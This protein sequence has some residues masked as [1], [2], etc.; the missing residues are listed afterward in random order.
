MQRNPLIK[1]PIVFFCV[2]LLVLLAHSSFAGI[3]LGDTITSTGEY[4]VVDANQLRGGSHTVSDMTLMYTIP[5]ARLK[6]GMSVW[7]VD[8]DSATDGKQGK[9]FRLN[10]P[11]GEIITPDP[12]DP[13]VITSDIDWDEV[14]A[15]LVDLSDHSVIELD[16]VTDAGSGEIITAAERSQLSKAYSWGDHAGKYLTS[17]TE[18]DPV[19]A[20]SDAAGIS[21]S[22]IVNWSN[23]YIWGN[24]NAAGYLK[25]LADHSV[26]ELNDVASAGSGSIITVEE[27]EKLEGIA[28]G[29]EDT[30]DD[31]WTGT[32][33]VYTNTGNVGIGTNSVPAKLTIFQEADTV[34]NA[35]LDKYG[36]VIANPAN[37]DNEEIGL[38]FRI[39]SAISAAKKPGAAITH[40]RTGGG[41]KGKMHFKTYDGTNLATKMTIDEAGNMGVG[42]ITPEYKL[43]VEGAVNAEEMFVGGKA[44]IGTTDPIANLTVY[45]EIDTPDDATADKFGLLIA[46][47]ENDTNEEVG[48][49]F[50]ISTT[51]GERVPGAAITHERTGTSSIGKL[52]FKTANSGYDL[53]TRMTIDEEGRVGIGTEEF[54]NIAGQSNGRLIIKATGW[55]ESAISA[56]SDTT[57]IYA[58]TTGNLASAING[59]TA[60]SGGVG[61]EGGSPNGKGVWGWTND[62]PYGVFGSNTENTGVYGEGG[63]SGVSGAIGVKGHAFGEGTGVY[64]SGKYGVKASG[65]SYDFYA[66]GG[67]PNYGT[68][69]G[70]HEVKLSRTSTDITSGMI[71]VIA[72]QAEIRDGSI[73]STLVSVEL[74]DRPMDKRVFGVFVAEQDLPEDHWY[75]PGEGER[76]AA[77]NAL[78]EGAVWVTD[79]NGP[80]ENGDYITTSAVPGY[81]QKQDDDFLHSY[82]VGKVLGD[83]DWDQITDTIEYNGKTY[84]KCLIAVTYHCG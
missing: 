61:V 64:G 12:D 51:L 23:A 20:A 44:G 83:V 32:E 78:G 71:V 81:G 3:E 29:A 19:F 67:G 73:S 48:L 8:V 6:E 14:S 70:A 18:T 69:T 74:A 46:N 40:E 72:G 75:T 79:V 77:V 11:V 39:S 60:V 13:E 26:T 52:H 65:T 37:N 34:D 9:M 42:K 38:G 15:G 58:K 49:G 21:Y 45:Q 4:A 2:S 16:D 56:E 68:F 28:A 63:Q 66:V 5:L 54:T 84:K 31:S 76:F 30:T 33:N 62:G 47:P 25:S 27:R 7:V 24:H 55:P 17:Y 22:Q 10:K 53:K 50:R 1:I 43:D 80:I 59:Y 41:S 57:T 35:T 36:L 82:T